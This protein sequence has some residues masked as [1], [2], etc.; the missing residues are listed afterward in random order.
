MS[1]IN[2]LKY[3][4][5]IN[6]IVPNKLRGQNFCIDQDVL[7]KMVKLSRVNRNDLVLEVGPGFGFLTL[8]LVKQAKEVVAIEFDT[9][10]IKP[11]TKLARLH[12]NLKIVNQDILKFDLTLLPSKKYKIVANL[13]YSITSYFFKRF[14]TGEIKPESITVLIQKEVAERIV[15][16]SG[17]LSLLAI[18]IQLYSTP[19]I[20]S[21]VKKDSFYPVPKVDSAILQ[22]NQ[23]KE[24]P[25]KAQVPE[26]VFWQVVRSGFS[27][28]RKQLHNNFKNSL[29]L[30]SKKVDLLFKKA[31]LSKEFRAQD[32][33]IN[34]WLKLAKSYQELFVDDI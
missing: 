27:A 9:G 24:Y 6:R 22:I 18:S 23:I 12:S 26:K 11:L 15:T 1:L 17:N 31:G 13:P 19:Q 16:A 10:L 30:D 20:L 8:E 2:E 32:L 14:L 29:H 28:K 21:I 7:N 4:L 34:D 25:F 33:E 5:D 3:L